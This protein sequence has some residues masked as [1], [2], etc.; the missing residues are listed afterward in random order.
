[1]FNKHGLM[2]FVNGVI[3][4]II[5]I[6]Q[7]INKFKIVIEYIV[8]YEPIIKSRHQISNETGNRVNFRDFEINEISSLIDSKVSKE[9]TYCYNFSLKLIYCFIL[10]FILYSLTDFFI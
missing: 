5:L 7:H 1:M 3:V 2:L 6:L 4:F 10:T 8:L 9:F